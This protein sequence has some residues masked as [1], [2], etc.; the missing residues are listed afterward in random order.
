M[1]TIKHKT[2][3]RHISSIGTK[4]FGW[5]A[6]P[7]ARRFLSSCPYPLSFGRGCGPSSAQI[8]MPSHLFHSSD[9]QPPRMCLLT[10]YSRGLRLSRAPS[11]RSIRT[12]GNSHSKRY[13][14]HSGSR[15]GR[16]S[17]ASGGRETLYSFGV[18]PPT[19]PRRKGS[20][21][22]VSP[23]PWSTSP[24]GLI[25]TMS[26]VVTSIASFQS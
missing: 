18:T 17:F 3:R 19:N 12:H 24:C 11:W 4:D 2:S 23:I 9:L 15:M 8:L 5:K 14:T 13:R 20:L 10:V 16:P 22:A 1:P 7:E 25:P 6:P 21:Y 26:N